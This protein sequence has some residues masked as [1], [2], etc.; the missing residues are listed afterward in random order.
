MVIRGCLAWSKCSIIDGYYYYLK[1]KK[2]YYV[3]LNLM[4]LIIVKISW[5]K[6][7]NQLHIVYSTMHKIMF[8]NVV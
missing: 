2:M 1:A 6:Y 4:A 5:E 8:L 3:F 7:R